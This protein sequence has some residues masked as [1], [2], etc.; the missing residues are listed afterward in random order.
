GFGDAGTYVVTFTAT[1]DGDGTGT[2]A[3]VT[4]HVPI[5]VL[6][7]N[8]PPAVT[9]ITNKQVDRGAT[10]DVPVQPSDA[11]GDPLLLQVTGL[12]RFGTFIDHGDGTGLL[13]FAPAAGDRGN[14]T[15]MVKASDNGDGGGAAAVLSDEQSF[16]LTVNVANEP[17]ELAPIG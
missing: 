15:L 14:F 2:P 17:P 1:D 3:S 7:T 13:H 8:R 16:V 10:L 11:D 5:T 4:T 9:A 6:N 12:P